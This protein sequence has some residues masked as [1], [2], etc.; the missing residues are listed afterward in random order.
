MTTIPPAT[1]SRPSWRGWTLAFAIALT[2]M[3]GQAAAATDSPA[4]LFA[5]A[6]GGRVPWLRSIAIFLVISVGGAYVWYFG[7]FPKLLRKRDPKWPLDAWRQASYGAWITMC[8]AAW[9]FKTP[10]TMDVLQPLLRGTVPGPLVDW[11]MELIL[12]PLLALVGLLVI[13]N[14]RREV[15]NR[16]RPT[17]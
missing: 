5:Q 12:L 3:T 2:S 14:F 9:V 13:W 17:T 16:A 8:A 6:A 10:L 11:F 1:W 15:A 4:V 7:L